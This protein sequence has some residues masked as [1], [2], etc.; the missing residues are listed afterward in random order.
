MTS[1]MHEDAEEFR[2]RV[3]EIAGEVFPELDFEVD[4]E[5]DDVIV[6]GQIRLGLQNLRAKC[7][8]GD[9]ADEE[10][11]TMV[12]DHFGPILRNETPS[13]DDLTLEELRDQLRLQLMPAEYAEVAPLPIIAFPFAKG[14]TIGIVADFPQAY[15]Y[16]RQADLKRWDTT[17]D[18][19]YEIALENLEEISRGIG[20]HLSKNDEDTFLAIDAGDGYDAAR[21]LLP[22]LQEFIATHLGE[23]FRFGIPNRD[24][25]ICWRLDS[26]ADLHRQFAEK[27]ADD[28]SERPYALS[29]SVFVRNSEGNFHEQSG[30]HGA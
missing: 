8:L 10:L 5:E 14:V 22:R 24:F 4:P 18:E 12:A 27:I 30:P 25:L 6:A 13:L 17:A 3:I 7:E 28:H 1:R 19:I 2:A 11:A 16:V 23:T 20:M 21:I 26:S 29:P 15:A 9:L